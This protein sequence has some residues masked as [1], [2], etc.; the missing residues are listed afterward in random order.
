MK[1]RLTGWKMVAAFLRISERAAR[2]LAHRS[3]PEELRL[4][5][6]RLLQGPSSPVCAHTDELVA[7][8][9]RIMKARRVVTGEEKKS[10]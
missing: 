6:Y 7:W 4:P 2:R 3:V 8:E 1:Q 10:T 5:V 9:E